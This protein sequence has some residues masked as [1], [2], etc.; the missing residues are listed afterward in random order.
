MLR[1]LKDSL[2]T[3]NKAPNDPFRA[4]L[5]KRIGPIEAAALEKPLRNLILCL[6][7]MLYQT[8]AWLDDPRVP[9]G[10]KRIHNFTLTYLYHPEDFLPDGDFGLFGYLDDAYLV[11]NVYMRT[12]ELMNLE[13]RPHLA[14]TE[15]LDRDVPLWLA[16]AKKAIAHEAG[17]INQM[18]DDLQD[19]RI[20]SFQNMLTK[21]G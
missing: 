2:I 3:L 18:L 8:R 6:P 11:A 9:V 15:R 16:A 5:E 17:M 4:T 12:M 7:E 20:D 19:G 1:A 10:L 13:S 21:M 14:H